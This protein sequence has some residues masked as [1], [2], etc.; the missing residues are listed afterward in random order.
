MRCVILE[1]ILILYDENRS[2][3]QKIVRSSDCSL[4]TREHEGGIA[5]NRKLVHYG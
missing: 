3:S 5:S 1:F 2:K 4:E